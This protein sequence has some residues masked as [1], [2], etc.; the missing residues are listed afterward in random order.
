MVCAIPI[1]GLSSAKFPIFFHDILFR[2]FLGFCSEHIREFSLT[3]THLISY[4]YKTRGKVH[5]ILPQQGD[6]QHDVINVVEYKSAASRILRFGLNKCKWMI[7]PMPA[8][9][10]VVGRMIAV[11]ET[12]TIGLCT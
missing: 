6:S 11:I 10:E 1:S 7:P 8:R 5:V 2:E 9:I 4:W 12:M 3:H